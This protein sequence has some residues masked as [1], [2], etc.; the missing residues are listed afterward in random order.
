MKYCNRIRF[1]YMTSKHVPGMN[2]NYPDFFQ[3]Y[4]ISAMKQKPTQFCWEF[5]KPLKGSLLN[6]PY[7]GKYLFFCS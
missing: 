3:Q 4:F 7:N 6:K 1:G 2:S 5:N